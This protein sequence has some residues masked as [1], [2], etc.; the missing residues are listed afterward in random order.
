ME[1]KLGML[2]INPK[3]PL[4]A[5]STRDGKVVLFSDLNTGVVVHGSD[6]G[7]LTDTWSECTNTMAWEILPAGTSITLIQE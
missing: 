7:Y 1:S 4:L 2:P 3:F 6:V 5:K